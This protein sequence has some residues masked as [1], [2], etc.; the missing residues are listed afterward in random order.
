MK[1]F[2]GLDNVKAYNLEGSIFQWAN[3]NRP[4]DGSEGV[5]PF[6]YV[7]GCLGLRWANWRWT[8][9]AGAASESLANN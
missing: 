2:S 7:W 9:P 3:E 8:V 6:S 5:H 4:L 1:H